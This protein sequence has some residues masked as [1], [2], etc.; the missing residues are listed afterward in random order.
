[1]IGS[2]FACTTFGGPLSLESYIW[3]FRYFTSVVHRDYRKCTVAG[4][5]GDWFPIRICNFWRT[6]ESGKLCIGIS[7][8]QFTEIIENVLSPDNVRVGSPFACTTSG[9]PPSPE[10]YVSVFQVGSHR[11]HRKRIVAGRRGDAEQGDAK[12]RAGQTAVR[13]THICRQYR[14]GRSA[15]NKQG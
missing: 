2:P 10:S 11:Y 8:R 4:R 12:P 3:V 5:H 6:T 13:P 7:Y 14:T 15:N 1:M 9:G